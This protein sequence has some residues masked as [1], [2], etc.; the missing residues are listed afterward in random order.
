MK[1]LRVCIS[2]GN[3]KMGDIPSVSLPAI[4]FCIKICACLAYC[5]AKRMQNFRKNVREA[6]IRNMKILLE[7]PEEFWR[8]VKEAVRKNRFF[9]YHVSGEIP[10]YEYFL[11]M[12]E[13]ASENPENDQLCFTKMY[14]IVNEYI[15]KNGFYPKNLHIL[16]SGDKNLEMNNPYHIPEAHIE[17]KDGT[18]TGEI[19]KNA[20]ACSGNCSHCSMAGEGCWALEIAESS[21][22]VQQVILKQH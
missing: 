16:F 14:D 13:T 21:D 5:Y 18:F 10:N 4:V 11:K 1:D 20:V 3:R 2:K 15:D 19:K 7:N 8:Q 6:Y 17:F 12:V 9:R 22:E